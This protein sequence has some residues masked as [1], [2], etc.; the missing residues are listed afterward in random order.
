VLRIEEIGEILEMVAGVIGNGKRASASSDSE[1]CSSSKRQKNAENSV[2]KQTNVADAMAFSWVLKKKPEN[3]KLTTET[4]PNRRTPEV[5]IYPD[6]PG[7]FQL[8][9]ETRSSLG[10]S[11]KGVSILAIDIS[12]QTSSNPNQRFISACNAVKHK[13]LKHEL[14]KI[15]GT[16]AVELMTYEVSHTLILLKNFSTKN[17]QHSKTNFA[18]TVR[19]DTS[20]PTMKSPP[21]EK[22]LPVSTS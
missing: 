17:P 19:N 1:S 20:G 12:S 22:G 6:A 16:K 4:L 13:S 18:K 5:H 14:V 3:S 7:L 11:V 8:E 2:E 15:Y 10:F 9:L 21:Q